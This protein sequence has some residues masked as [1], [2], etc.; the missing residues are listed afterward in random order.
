MLEWLMLT[1]AVLGALAASYTDIKHGII[2]N[3]LSFS[4]FFAGIAGNIAIAFSK[5]SYSLA[6]DLGKAVLVTFAVGYTL[7]LLGGMAAGD[8]KEFLFIAA[9]LPKYPEVLLRYFSPSLAWYPFPLSVFINTFVAIFPFLFIYSLAISVKKVRI[10]EFFEPLLEPQKKLKSAFL[11]IGAFSFGALLG[12]SIAA[13][14]FILLIYLIKGEIY[15]IAA[16]SAML[17][18]ALYTGSVEPIA[19][20]KY[21]IFIT[22][23]L[24]LFTLFWNSLKILRGSLKK[25]VKISNLEEGVIAAEEIYI[26]NGEVIREEKDFLEKI[27]DYISRETM[28]RGT[29][30]AG[31]GAGGL[32][33]QQIETLQRLVRE[34]R[35]E[36]RVKV[37]ARMPFAPVILLGLLLA[38]GFGDLSRMVRL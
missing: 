33:A 38:L 9:L 17:L 5:G 36:D 21:Y 12:K 1:L 23:V 2:P 29:L 32:T 3:K 19:L 27:K 31:T 22:V 7:W 18:L 13:L 34:G 25:E 26:R 16:A 28:S 15:R 14:G 11:L 8:V 10:R 4:L 20:L 35:L 30:V 37:K 6:L 24:L